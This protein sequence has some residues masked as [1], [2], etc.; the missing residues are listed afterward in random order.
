MKELTF[1]PKINNYKP[2]KELKQLKDRVTDELLKRQEK[3]H[4]VAS[5]MEGYNPSGNIES[6]NKFMG[7]IDGAQYNPKKK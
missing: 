3:L 4:K 1:K 6:Q 5:E 7:G 2:K